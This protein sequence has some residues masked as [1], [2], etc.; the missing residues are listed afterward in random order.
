MR[1]EL[2]FA[3]FPTYGPRV[4][5]SSEEPGSVG[6]VMHR[7]VCAGS[8]VRGVVVHRPGSL[9]YLTSDGNRILESRSTPQVSS[10]QIAGNLEI[11]KVVLACQRGCNIS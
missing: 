7:S 10:G 5:S 3:K 11:G 2:R 1:D 6:F 8:L 4:G 9:S